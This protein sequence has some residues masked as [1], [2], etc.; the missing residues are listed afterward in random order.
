MLLSSWVSRTWQHYKKQFSQE[1]ENQGRTSA[2]F[3]ALAVNTEQLTAV[4]FREVNSRTFTAR[5]VNK[6]FEAQGDVNLLG[7]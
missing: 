3:T 6:G 1:W 4:A 7:L 5:A 2:H